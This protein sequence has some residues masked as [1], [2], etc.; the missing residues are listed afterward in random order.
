MDTTPTPPH[1]DGT[2][3]NGLDLGQIIQS[4]Q[5]GDLQTLL[6]SAAVLGFVAL[7]VAGVVWV[8]LHRKRGGRIQVTRSGRIILPVVVLAIGILA[9][10]NPFRMGLSLR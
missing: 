6:V 4:L 3:V 9:I 2:P 5:Q 7:A 8:V 10:T 1:A